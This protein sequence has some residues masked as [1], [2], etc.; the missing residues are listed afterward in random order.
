MTASSTR[1][2]RAE[3]TRQRICAAAKALF[4]DRG[5]TG[6][7]IAEI[8]REAGVAS[9]TVYFV[10]GS[11]AAVLS[12]VMDA[13]IVGDFAPVPLLDR[14]Q[15][16]ALARITDPLRRMERIVA[17][18]CQITQRVAPVY[19]IVRSGAADQE[20]RDLLDRSEE[21]RW[22]SIRGFIGL[23]ESDLAPGLTVEEAVD[24]LYALLSHDLY[25]L[26]VCRRGWS[27]A[28]WRAYVTERARRELL[29]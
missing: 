22:R 14:P 26:L 15:V 5:Y 16:K 17:L 11:K 23:A 28:R 6:T 4:L 18:T 7:T 29:P 3:H 13:E 2:Q 21:G 9:Q 10:F 1:Q 8:A 19:E 25:W 12:A 20:V 24:R 27:G